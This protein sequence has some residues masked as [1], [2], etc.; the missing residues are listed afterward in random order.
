MQDTV[1]TLPD[2]LRGALREPLGPVVTDVDTLLDGV[3][4]PIVTV[5]DI[6]T[7]HLLE[8]GVEP[9]LVV[10]D[11][12]TERA[13]V[14]EAV[15][16]RLPFDRGR[17][18]PNAAGTLSAELVSAMVTAIDRNQPGEVLVVDGEEDLAA[19]PAVLAI[20]ADGVVVYGQ[21]GEGM[22]RAVPDTETRDRVRT[23]LER[24]DGSERLWR[25]LP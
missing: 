25:L 14:D 4:G 16:R 22:V 5:G 9:L 24:F 23:L 21:P 3:S 20:P 11:G 2:D 19:L 17:T 6:V 15:R 8:A 10:V 1:A 18:V 7:D 12:R 13:A